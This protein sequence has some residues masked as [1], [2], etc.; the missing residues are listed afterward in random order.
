MIH[1]EIQHQGAQK[2]WAAAAAAGETHLMTLT[3]LANAAAR[4]GV[5]ADL[6]IP[7]E[8]GGN[9]KFGLRYA[10]EL[11]VSMNVAPVAGATI[12]LWWAPSHNATTFP[13]GASGTDAAYTGLGGGGALADSKLQLL[14]VGALILDATV[15]TQRQHFIFTP[16][17]RYGS[18]I[19]VNLGGQAFDAGTAH[20][21]TLTEL[22]KE[23]G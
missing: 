2:I 1:T 11:Q 19:V 20:R 6:G 21:V 17:A 12:E 23:S 22:L 15:V 13:G 7:R 16:P 4:Q 18:P 8:G 3:S 14:L 5:Y 10:A 9:F